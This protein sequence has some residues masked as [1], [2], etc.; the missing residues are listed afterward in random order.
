ML[1]R[2]TLLLAVLA[3]LCPCCLAEEEE[4]EFFF[5]VPVPEETVQQEEAQEAH[6]KERLSRETLMS[7]FTDS[8]FVGDSVTERVRTYVKDQRKEE[9]PGLLSNAKFLVKQSY[10]LFMA[11]KNYVSQKSANLTYNGREMSLCNIMGAMKPK[12]VFIL[13]GINDYIG[14]K[15][16]KGMEYVTR[17]V[18]LIHKYSPDTE[19][20]FQSLTPVTR[21]FCKRKDFRTM[22][23]EYNEALKKL[24]ETVDFTYIEIAAGLKDEEGY[25]PDEWSTDREYHVNNKGIPIWIDELLDFAQQQYEQGLWTPE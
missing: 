16:D 6:K 4:D 11:S 17:T 14:E 10:M 25:L 13:L 2:L 22:W 20:Y 24:S 18:E 9:E 5:S 19:I 12:R 8:A 7:F 15:I 21:N 1:K 3:L 23:D